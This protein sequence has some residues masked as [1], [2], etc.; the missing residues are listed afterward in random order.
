MYRDCSCQEIIS[1]EKALD[2]RASDLV[3]KV[4]SLCAERSRNRKRLESFRYWISIPLLGSVVH[5]L[6][7][8]PPGLEP[9]QDLL[10]FDWY[11]K[12][13]S[14]IR[15]HTKLLERMKADHLEH[16]SDE[17]VHAEFYGD[18]AGYYEGCHP[19]NPMPRNKAYKT[20]IVEGRQERLVIS[21]PKK[22]NF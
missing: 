16:W 14:T 8:M 18:Y 2:K 17:L 6:L 5:G 10:N 9:E 21:A 4:D 19:K 11:K 3:E 15:E 1:L 20:Y 13:G 12:E 22:Y 7:K